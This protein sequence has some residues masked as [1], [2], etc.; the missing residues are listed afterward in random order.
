MIRGVVLSPDDARQLQQLKRDVA[1]LLSRIQRTERRYDF[2]D[3]PEIWCEV[4][5]VAADWLVC[6]PLNIEDTND[7]SQDFKVAK[8]LD[9][10]KTFTHGETIK[11]KDDDNETYTVSHDSDVTL[12][13]RTLTKVSDSS[14]E[15]QVIVP[16][17]ISRD[18]ISSVVYPGSYIM[19]RKPSCG[20]RTFDADGNE[21]PWIDVS[22]RA[23]AK[24]T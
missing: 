4:I 6:R 18:T 16:R 3:S 23:W 9:L 20:T 21:I 12:Q 11:T 10:Q 14:T 1:D 19:A 8:M 22:P 15:T 13:K 24:S 2:R 5:S 17:Y 7:S